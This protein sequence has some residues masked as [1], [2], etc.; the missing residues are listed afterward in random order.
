[1]RRSDRQVFGEDLNG[2]LKRAKV[3][4]LAM[5]DNGR[6][7]IV[8]MNFG[9]EFS[10]GLPTLYFHCALEG[11]KLD[12]LSKNPGVCFEADG[13]H[14]LVEKQTACAYSFAYESAIGEGTAEILHDRAQKAD[15]LMKIMAHQTGRENFEFSLD[16]IDNVCVFK[17]TADSMTGKRVGC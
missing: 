9:V 17:V 7:Y 3:V 5:V 13:A 14:R 10:D 6:P 12:I 4:R 11:R 15:A 8:P 1:M 2:I 16:T